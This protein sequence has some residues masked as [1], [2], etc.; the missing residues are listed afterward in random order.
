MTMASTGDENPFRDPTHASS[1][2]ELTNE[3]PVTL[4][5]GRNASL[6]LATDSLVVL[7]RFALPKA[8][9]EISVCTN[10]V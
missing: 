10:Q 8:S 4:A 7:G 1:T 3:V 5:V 2:T 9:I 6:T